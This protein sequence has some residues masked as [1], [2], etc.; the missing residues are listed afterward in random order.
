MNVINRV[1]VLYDVLADSVIRSFKYNPAACPILTCL[2]V[3]AIL[4][5]PPAPFHL[6]ST[7]EET[8]MSQQVSEKVMQ[9]KK[10]PVFKQFS[11]PHSFY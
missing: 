10:G 4:S 3:W 6:A 11:Q 8:V 1:Q 5:V 9:S 7:L 2:A